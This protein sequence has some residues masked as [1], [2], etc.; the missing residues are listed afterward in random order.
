MKTVQYER[1][2]PPHGGSP[3]IPDHIRK[4]IYTARQEG[5]MVKTIAEQYGICRPTVRRILNEEK[6]K[7]ARR[8]GPLGAT[9]VIGHTWYKIKGNLVFYWWSEMQ[10]W[11]RSTITPS[12]LRRDGERVV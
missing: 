2:L 10:E 11:W 12:E 1:K 8:I 9:H 7:Q 3:Q 4:E 5:V 6:A